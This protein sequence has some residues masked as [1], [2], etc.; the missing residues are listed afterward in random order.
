MIACYILFSPA[1]KLFYTGFVLDS[2]EERLK[3]HNEGFYE[4]SFTSFTNDWEL[5]LLIECD[6]NHQAISIEKHI[7]K[8]KSKIYIQNLKKYP[9]MISKLKEKFSN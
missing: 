3:K 5:F 2:F 4:K 7:K 8:M 1:K 6:T 9:E